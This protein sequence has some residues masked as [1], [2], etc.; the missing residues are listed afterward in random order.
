MGN[1]LGSWTSPF[2]RNVLPV[3]DFGSSAK[4][5]TLLPSYRMKMLLLALLFWRHPCQNPAGGFG[6]VGEE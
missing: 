1:R 6:A 4:S 2:R 5:P 3:A